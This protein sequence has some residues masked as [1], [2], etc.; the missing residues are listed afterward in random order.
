MLHQ[1]SH[2]QVIATYE[3]GAA[4]LEGLQRQQPDVLLL[5]VQLP[6]KNGDELTGIISRK[7]PSVRILILTSHDSIYYI[8]TL[9]RKGAKG[10]ILKTS[11]QDFLVQAI[12]TVFTGKSFYSPEVN[13]TLVQDTLKIKP[14]VSLF[15]QLTPRERE[16]LQLIYEEHTSHEIAE[17][18]HIS[19]RTVEN[20]RLGMMQKLDSKNMIGMVKKALQLG[21]IK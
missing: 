2:I 5:D 15:R 13:E 4:L 8:K 14:P 17:K 6:D 21:L 11:G 9:L 12:E 1:C 16:I 3:N 19:Y 10:Y 7:Y 20:Y 18:L